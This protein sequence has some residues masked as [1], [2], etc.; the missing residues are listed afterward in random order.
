MP[1]LA[2]AVLQLACETTIYSCKRILEQLHARRP[3][4]DEPLPPHATEFHGYSL[5]DPLHPPDLASIWMK[6][7]PRV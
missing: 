1:E 7:N 2:R 5:G 3:L 6:G 4:H